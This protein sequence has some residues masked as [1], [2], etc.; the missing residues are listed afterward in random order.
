LPFFYAPL[1]S[2][3]KII[4]NSLT[5]ILSRLF[6]FFLLPRSYRDSALIQRSGFSPRIF[7]SNIPQPKRE[8]ILAH[9]LIC[10]FSPRMIRTAKSDSK[11]CACDTRHATRSGLS[12]RAAAQLGKEG[13]PPSVA[14]FPWPPPA[15]GTETRAVSEPSV[16]AAKPASPGVRA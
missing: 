5:R 4:R 6:S 1:T 12:A 14:S 7:L 13:V 3:T 11:L 8:K 16:S 15:A 2:P 9:N 10:R